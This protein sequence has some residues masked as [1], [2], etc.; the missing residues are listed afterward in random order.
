MPDLP[1]ELPPAGIAGASI[2]DTPV[3]TAARTPPPVSGGTLLALREGGRAAVSDSDRDRIVVVDFD[4]NS[5]VANIAFEAGTEPGRL[6]ED[7]AGR[8][9]ALL[10]G[11]GEL[12]SI[13][14]TAHRVLARRKACDAPRG[15]VY[16]PSSDRLLVACLE[17]SLVELP[18]AGGPVARVTELDSDLRDVTFVG[19]QLVVTRFRSAELL[20]LDEN[21]QIARR[22]KVPGA[23]DGF[24]P[25]VAWRSIATAD[26]MLAIAHQRSFSGRVEVSGSGGTSSAGVTPTDVD[27]GSS[28]P[29]SGGTAGTNTGEAGAGVD[30]GFAQPAVPDQNGYGSAITPC[31]SVVQGTLSLVAADGSIQAGPNLDRAVLPVDVAMTSTYVAVVFAGSHAGGVGVYTRGDFFAAPATNCLALRRVSPFDEAVA[32]AFEPENG[33]L[34]VQRR[35]PA[36][37]YVLDAD[38]YD[39]GHPIELGGGS[40]F[41]TGHDIFHSDSGAGIACASCHPEGTEDGRVWH[42]SD[43]GTRRTQPLDVGLAGTAPF[44]WDGELAD[45]SELMEHIFVD[46][47]GGPFESSAREQ[48]LE[49]YVYALPRRPARRDANDAAAQRGKLLFESAATG[50]STC[51]SGP[52]FSSGGFGD[53]GKGPAL[54]VPSLIAVSARAPYMHDGCAATLLDRFD[55]ACGGSTHGDVSTLSADDLADLVAYLESL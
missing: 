15:L 29:A 19:D 10:R 25:S 3:V 41:D 24:D 43:V 36:E 5:V 54:Q 1:P 4:A 22:V 7:G 9:H 50:C 11:T 30:P 47:M 45:F 32:V 35:E 49:E 46:R 31:G 34:L 16:E 17:G 21:R 48:A 8:V 13:D 12:V 6:V 53:I 2:D 42:F 18:A 28:A 51:H 33:K 38:G 55:P 44:H 52:N 27:A 14:V 20:Y 40:V 23:G 26:G 37:L 39:S